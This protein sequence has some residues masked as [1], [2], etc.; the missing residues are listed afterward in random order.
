V[1]GKKDDASAAVQATF[2]NV[3]GFESIADDGGFIQ[4]ISG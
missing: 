3:A 1:S 2:V 4:T